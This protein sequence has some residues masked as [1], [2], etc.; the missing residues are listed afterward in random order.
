M[1]RQSTMSLLERMSG[2]KILV[3]G[4][5]MLDQFL[6]GRVNR[7]SPEAPVPVVDVERETFS[8]GGAGNVVMNVLSLGATPIPVGVCGEDWAGTR[9]VELMERAGVKTEHMLRGASPTTLKTRIIAHQQQVVRV[10]REQRAF[11]DQ[12]MQQKI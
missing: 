4:D 1:D 8:I 9:M 2:R 5:F 6:W 11:A 12:T 7:I 10:D 3:I